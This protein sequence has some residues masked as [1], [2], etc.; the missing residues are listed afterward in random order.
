MTQTINLQKPNIH[1][2]NRNLKSVPCLPIRVLLL[3]STEAA[4]PEPDDDDITSEIIANN[5]SF[6]VL[7]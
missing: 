4:A 3:E 6:W 7:E 2:P 1:S 5:V